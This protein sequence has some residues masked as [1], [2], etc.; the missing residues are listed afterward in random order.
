MANKT[1]AEL[2]AA[3]ALDGTELLHLV[4]GGNSRK[5]TAL[6]LLAQL[7]ENDLSTEFDDADRILARANLG[8][9]A[10]SLIGTGHI[11]QSVAA[12][13]YAS[14][15]NLSTTMPADDSIPQ[16]TEGTQILTLSITPKFSTSKLRLRFR[17]EVTAP[18]ADRI[19]AAL[20]RDSGANAIAASSIVFEANRAATLT[21]ERDVA[22]SSTS[23]T[24]FTVRVGANSLTTVRMNGS[25]SG[26]LL[27]G[28][29][30]ATLVCEEISA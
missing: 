13:P 24:T 1:I 6:A 20:F 5:A 15:N 21:L 11:I 30:G 10:A 28:T 22:A 17:G 19:Q 23:A 16:I 12:T 2:T 18:D 26:R 25:P 29:S 4:Q 8:A 14:N 3:A 9:L 7:F 27:G